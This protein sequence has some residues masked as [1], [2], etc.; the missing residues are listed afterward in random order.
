MIPPTYIFSR[1]IHIVPYPILTDTLKGQKLLR[2]NWKSPSQCPRAEGC[3]G[4]LSWGQWGELSSSSLLQQSTYSPREITWR[5]QNQRWVGEAQRAEGWEDLLVSLRQCR[6]QEEMDLQKNLIKSRAW[7]RLPFAYALSRSLWKG[8]AIMQCL[9]HTGL[10]GKL[11]RDCRRQIP[12]SYFQR[13]HY[14]TVAVPFY[15]C[16]YSCRCLCSAI[17]WLVP[18]TGWS[19]RDK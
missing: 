7:P 8:A 1:S 11:P 5:L 3:R 6:L 16:M 12:R 4:P 9:R 10:E 15:Q 18:Q 2:S 14:N 13:D 17:I 19:S